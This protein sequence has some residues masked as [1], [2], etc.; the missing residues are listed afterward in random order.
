MATELDL[1]VDIKSAREQSARGFGT[2]AAVTAGQKMRVRQ[3]RVIPVVFLPGI[4]GSNIRITSD[5]RM[6]QLR[7]DP[8]EAESNIAWRPDSL[9]ITNVSENANLTAAQRQLILDP[10][11]TAVDIYSPGSRN[12]D[13]DGDGRHDNVDLDWSFSSPLMT[14]ADGLDDEQK[15]RRRGWG[16]T[17][18]DSYGDLLQTLEQRLNRMFNVHGRGQRSLASGWSEIVGVDPK[19][20]MLDK[21][22][23][24]PALT[25]AELRKIGTDCWFPVY[26]IGYN[27][28][29]DNRVS[30]QAVA[31]RIKAIR[32]AFVQREF[33]CKGVIVVTHS[34]GG[35]V[36]RSLIHPEHGGLNDLVLGVIHGVQPA[37][38]AAAA[39]KRMHAGF[40]GSGLVTRVLGDTG[41]LVTA[42][43]ANS[44]GGLQLLPSQAYGNGWLKVTLKG[45]ELLSLPTRGDPYEE[46]YKLRHKWYG[47]LP[48]EDWINPAK[49]PPTKSAAPGFEQTMGYLDAAKQFHAD[50]SSTYHVRTYAHYGADKEHKAFGTVTWNIS[51]NCRNPGGWQDWPILGNSTRGRLTFAEFKP[52]GQGAL[53]PAFGDMP[54]SGAYNTTPITATIQPPNEAGDETV[55][56]RSA[57]HQMRVGRPKAVFRQTGYDHQNSYKNDMA[58]HATIYSILRIALEVFP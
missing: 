56:M 41:E 23:P 57:D 6:R 4:M 54:R 36:A 27:W 19:E 28:L 10:N 47:L 17:F 49:L 16:E 42:V 45:Q 3:T 1:G 30:A 26:A 15:A 31:K 37:I 33:E 52:A 35:L 22:T 55:P 18:F 9:G 43:V 48:T 14:G 58:V 20:W 51:D 34:M 53:H 39:Y 44:P 21:S 8:D 38:G 7:R 29:Q 12:P 24:H 32:A 5:E 40:E 25:E 13:R 2:P 50:I 11:T 46:I